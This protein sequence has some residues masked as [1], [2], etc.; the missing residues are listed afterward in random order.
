MVEI[1]P[2]LFITPL[3]AI[4]SML[5]V[6]GYTMAVDPR[7]FSIQKSAIDRDSLILPEVIIEDYGNDMAKLLRPAFDVVWQATGFSGSLNYDD[8]NNWVGH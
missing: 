4:I 1:P 5:G 7:V 8:N 6:K 3:L 2:T